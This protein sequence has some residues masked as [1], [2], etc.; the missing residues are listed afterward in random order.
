MSIEMKKTTQARLPAEMIPII[1]DIK[2]FREKKLEPTSTKSIII[3]ALKI[4]H[5]QISDA[6]G[7]SAD[8]VEA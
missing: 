7:G 8:G 3:D 4:M 2:A 6:S 1:K 5:S